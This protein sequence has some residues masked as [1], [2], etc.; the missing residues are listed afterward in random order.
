MDDS[1]TE[2]RLVGSGTKIQ[3]S[4]ELATLNLDRVG[5]ALVPLATARGSVTSVAYFVDL[6]LFRT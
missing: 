4:N 6:E 5:C 2:P 3:F 1:G